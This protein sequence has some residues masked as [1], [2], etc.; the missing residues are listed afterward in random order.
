MSKMRRVATMVAAAAVAAGLGTVATG[1]PA[2]ASSGPRPVAKWLSAV[3]AGEP[4]WV[5]IHW[6]TDTKI[7]DAQ[8]WVKGNNTVDIEYPS[9]TMKYTSFS[10]DD[11]LKPWEKDRTAFEVTAN[12]TKAGTRQLEATLIYTNCKSDKAKVKSFKLYLPVLV[13]DDYQY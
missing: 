1:A 9:T 7:C 4:T 2:A 12:Q 8:V 10:R 11:M 6:T 3:E 5:N 13:D